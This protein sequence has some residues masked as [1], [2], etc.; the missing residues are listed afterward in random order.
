MLVACV[1]LLA[2]STGA[3]ANGLESYVA[4][5]DTNHSWRVVDSKH[6][7]GFAVTHVEMTSQK[8]RE[9]LWTHHMQIVR[10]DKVR[11]PQFAFLYVSGSGEGRSSIP[12]LKI[13]ADRAG[14]VAAVVTRVPNQPLY[15]GRREDALIA[16]TFDQYLKTGDDSWP[17]IFP[18][19][20][21]A[22]RAMDTVQAFA[23]KEHQQKV[24]GFVVAGASLFPSSSMVGT[25][26]HPG[27]NASPATQNTLP[28]H[29]RNAAEWRR[30]DHTKI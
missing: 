3:C 21:S 7:D 8:W 6:A 10:P 23:E 12:M 17:L 22:M 18:M 30:A 15:D 4:R 24:E 28:I 14:A 1:P 19:V 13:I 26:S 16:Y 20:R 11:N 27:Q 9:H 5:A 2:D 29:P 25:N